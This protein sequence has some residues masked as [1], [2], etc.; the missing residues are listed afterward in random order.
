MATNKINV[1]SDTI[2]LA[3]TYRCENC[4][5]WQALEPGELSGKTGLC[6]AHPPVFIGLNGDGTPEFAQPIT[7]IYATCGEW[8]EFNECKLPNG[9]IA[10]GHYRWIFPSDS[11]DS[12]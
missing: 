4:C 1:D 9:R 3:P 8:G 2:V 7:G 12:M 10:E 6:V 5:F 11:G